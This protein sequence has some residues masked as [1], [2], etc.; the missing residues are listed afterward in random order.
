MAEAALFSLATDI[1]KSLATEIAKPAG[2]FFFRQIK[3]LRGAKDEL[4][5][6]EG[7][8]QAIRAVLLDAEKQQWDKHQVKLWLKRLK[9]VL[10]DVQD[11][12]DDVATE[13]LRR[14]VTPGNKMSKSVR[15]FFSKSNQ[16]AQRLKV[17]NKIQEL[18]R[19]LDEIEN[20]SKLL[21][22]EL[23]PEETMAIGRGKKPERPSPDAKIIG[24]EEDKMKIKQL[25]LSSSSNKS[26][27]FVA[28][29]GKGGLGK[30]ALA[31]LVYD[32]GEV[33]EHF[34]LKMWVCVS[35]VFDVNSLIKELLKKANVDCQGRHDEDL[36]SLLRETLGRKKY[37]LVLDDLW[38]EDRHEWLKLGDWLEGG[39]WG[40]KILVT[41]RSHE[42]AKVTN[43]RSV[44]Y[45]L[46]GLSEDESWNL[47]K[48][49][50]FEDGEES[51][52]SEQE[53]IGRDLVKKCAGVPLAVRTIGS[54]LYGKKKD[55]WLCYEGRE[56]LDIP[57]I[58]EKDGGIMEVLKFSYDHLPSRLKHCFAYCSLF[59]KNYVY[60]K[61]MVIHLWVAEGFIESHNGEDNLEEV[62]DMYLSELLWRSFLDVERK[63]KDG[64]VIAFKM[65]DL[66]HDLAQKV[67]EGE[68]EIVNFEGRHNGRGIRHASFT[69]EFFS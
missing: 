40:S 21:K 69:S 64:K 15:I 3:L 58:A 49:N 18:R 11:L 20:D 37:L 9:D 17:A 66:M 36:P 38:N 16:L 42:V 63:G 60:D 56:L 23:H 2:S 57:E 52:D 25:L 68:C 45:D 5:S 47:F 13:D 48:K 1:L 12:L 50:A 43:A 55:E 6:L 28:I 24:R 39:Q 29:V 41:T 4:R 26:V 54:L 65:H 30:T 7:T 53:K 34:G 51:L 35:D 14:E 59:P 8:V 62:A 19:T 27:S 61:E 10:Y 22:L 32:D 44:I 46:R 67:A 33:K 31:R